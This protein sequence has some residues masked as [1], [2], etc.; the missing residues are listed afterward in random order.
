MHRRTFLAATAA[1]IA[2]PALAQPEPKATESSKPKRTLRKAVM[3]GMVGE[4]NSVLEKF[5]I[6]RDCGFEGAELDSPSTTPPDE[7]LAAMD[8]TGLKVHGL[9]D[10]VHWRHHLNDPTDSR[11]K[12][13][14]ALKTALRD[15][16]K[17]GSISVLLVPAVVNDKLPYDKAW[18]LS[19]DAIKQCLPLAQETGVKIAIE[20]VWNSFLFSP[21]EAKRYLEEI[22]SPLVGW[23]FDIGNVITFGWP[24]QWVRILGPSI[25]KLHIK[26]FSRKKRNDEGYPKGFDVE[27]GEGDANWPALMKALDDIGYSTAPNGNWATAE[28]R[29]GDRARLKT[30]SEQMDKLF[31]M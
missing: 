21:L 15:G 2:A 28:V 10:S 6:L 19:I 3:I 23:H 16:K 7:I 9:V 24:D 30:I 22:N 29:G 8:K 4:G 25:L 27:L 18:Q 11:E 26:D 13:I 20:N 5:Q 31:A 14:E 12:A 17:F 1:T